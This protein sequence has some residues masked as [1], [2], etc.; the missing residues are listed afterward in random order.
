MGLMKVIAE[1][2][3]ERYLRNHPEKSWEEAMEWACSKYDITREDNDVNDT[4][5]DPFGI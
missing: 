4:V 1:E 5:Q 3:A 2:A